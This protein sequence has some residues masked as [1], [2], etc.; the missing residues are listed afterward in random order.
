VLAPA[1]AHAQSGSIKGRV[2]DA[3]DQPVEGATIS[4][5]STDKGGKPIT[6]KTNKR[7]EYM[8][9][10]L[11]P[12]HYKVTVSKGDLTTTRETDVHLDMLNFD[13]KLVPGGGGGGATASKEEAAKNEKIKTA[14]A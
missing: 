3:Q 9:V 4:L 14:F 13:V 11:S 1:P 12:G 10:G 2:T 5:A 8:Q 7:G 6:V